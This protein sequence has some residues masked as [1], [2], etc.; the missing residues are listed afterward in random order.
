MFKVKPLG[1][2]YQLLQS[3]VP[4]VLGRRIVHNVFQI[5]RRLARIV[6]SIIKGRKDAPP[7]PFAGSN[8]FDYF[9]DPG[10][11]KGETPSANANCSARG[12]AKLGAMMSAGGTLEGKQFLTPDAWQAMQGGQFRG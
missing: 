7:P 9:N 5:V 6:P 1:F 8:I 11:A 3:L 10:F 2:G 4:R 12:L